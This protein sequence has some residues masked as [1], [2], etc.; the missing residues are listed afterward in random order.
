MTECD[1]LAIAERMELYL[2]EATNL[3]K[4]WFGTEVS[5]QPALVVQMASAM[6]QREGAEVLAMAINRMKEL[7]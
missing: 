6:L 1:P 4:A 7:D 2:D 5:D 3:A